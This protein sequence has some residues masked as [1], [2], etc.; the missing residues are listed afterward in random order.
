MSIKITVEAGETIPESKIYSAGESKHIIKPS[1]QEIFNLTDGQMYKA[2][3]QWAWEKVTEESLKAFKKPGILPLILALIPKDVMLHEPTEWELYPQQNW[4]ETTVDAKPYEMEILEIVPDLIAGNQTILSNTSSVTTTQTVDLEYT[5]ESSATDSWSTEQAVGI[6]ESI[7][8]EYRFMG[9]D[10]TLSYEQTW[11]Q[12][13][14]H[15]YSDAIT[16]KISTNVTLEPGQQVIAKLIIVQNAMRIKIQYLSKVNGDATANYNPPFLDHHFYRMPASKLPEYIGLTS[17]SC[18][19][20]EIIDVK[21]FS[22]A[23]VQ[24]EDFETGKVISR[25]PCQKEKAKAEAA[26]YT[27]KL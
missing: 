25:I 9:S 26:R 27:K 14:S 10:T 8:F 21:F 17:S 20:E 3:M 5:Q 22:T 15:T 1:E 19:T 18:L 2:W 24:T 16:T 6:D 23:F 13:E 4:D 12:T 7:S 11:G